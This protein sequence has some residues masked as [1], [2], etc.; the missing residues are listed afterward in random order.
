MQDIKD[1]GLACVEGETSAESNTV[2]E[3]PTND[4][5]IVIVQ[6]KNE[7]T[8]R[9]ETTTI[10]LNPK[11]INSEKDTTKIFK[12]DYTLYGLGIFAIFLMLLFLLR[13]KNDKNEFG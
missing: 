4:E 1:Q 13:R 10:S 11:D 3:N 8:E 12:S 6:T 7:E 9:K 5:P 2:E